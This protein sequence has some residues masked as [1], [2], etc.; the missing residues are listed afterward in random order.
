[1]RIR[2]GAERSALVE[3]R[4][5]RSGGEEVGGYMDGSGLLRESDKVP[6]GELGGIQCYDM[7]GRIGLTDLPYE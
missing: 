5:R 7:S 4:M 1:M 3:I 6:P 2:S